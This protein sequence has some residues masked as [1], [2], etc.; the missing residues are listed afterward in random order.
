MAKSRGETTTRPEPRTVCE[1]CLGSRLDRFVQTLRDSARTSTTPA[2]KNAIG[3]VTSRAARLW[4]ICRKLSS[5]AMPAVKA[6]VTELPESRVRVE[7]E[8]LPEEV[9][10]RLNE[11]AEQLGRRMRV[12]GFRKGK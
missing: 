1:G 6:S 12:P 10:R 4:S 5:P 8:V 11:A 9:Q 2:A 7:A 3:P